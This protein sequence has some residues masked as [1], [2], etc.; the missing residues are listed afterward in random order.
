MDF[1]KGDPINVEGG[2]IKKKE[3]ICC[4]G[5]VQKALSYLGGSGGG[6]GEKMRNRKYV[7]NENLFNNI[8]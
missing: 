4:S 7:K 1:T 2:G 3:K 8:N 5:L 6:G